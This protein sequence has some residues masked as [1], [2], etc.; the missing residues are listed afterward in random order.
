MPICFRC[1]YNVVLGTAKNPA[2]LKYIAIQLFDLYNFRISWFSLK[3][4]D[5]F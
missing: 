3:S 1:K 2:D 4:G 5:L